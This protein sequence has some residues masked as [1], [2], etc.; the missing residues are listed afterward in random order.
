MSKALNC[1]E[2]WL[3]STPKTY[4][5]TC[6]RDEYNWIECKILPSGAFLSNKTVQIAQKALCSSYVLEQI[7][8]AANLALEQVRMLQIQD[9]PVILSLVANQEFQVTPNSWRF[10]FYGPTSQVSG[11]TYRH[12]ADQMRGWMHDPFRTFLTGVVRI[13]C[14]FQE[15]EDIKVSSFENPWSEF[16]GFGTKL[17]PPSLQLLRKENFDPILKYKAS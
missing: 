6:Y 15:Q 10:F 14:R 3:R 17:P 11:N 2:K 8:N 5:T 4:E 13:E 16:S 7:D 12:D 1:F 9:T